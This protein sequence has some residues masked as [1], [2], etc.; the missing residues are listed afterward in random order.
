MARTLT[1]LHARRKL[2]RYCISIVDQAQ[3]DPRRPEALQKLQ[4]QLAS[5]DAQIAEITGK[6]PDVVVGLKPARLFAE[7]K[8]VK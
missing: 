2:A 5:I 1:E 8:G 3:D 6:P 7:P 4:A